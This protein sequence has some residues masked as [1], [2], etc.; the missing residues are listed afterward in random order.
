MFVWDCSFRGTADISNIDGFENVRLNYVLC[1]SIF[2]AKLL[3]F[4]EYNIKYLY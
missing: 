1:I 3:L 2:L 4:K